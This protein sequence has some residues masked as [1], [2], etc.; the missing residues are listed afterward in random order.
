MA[1]YHLSVKTF[2]RAKAHAATAAAAYR[3]ADRIY[4]ERTGVTHDYTRK[5]G[6]LHCEVVLPEAAPHW[7]EKRE[8]LWNQAEAAEHRKNSTVAR[9]FELALPNEL[10]A[11]LRTELA[12]AFTRELVDRHGFAA[13][14]ALHEPH[15]E[16]DQRNYHAHI[17]VTTR[18]LVSAGFTDKTRELDAN[19]DQIEHWR[20]RWADLQNEYLRE[21]GHDARVDH[22]TLKEQGFVR[23]PGRH[24]G[25]AITALERRGERTVVLERRREDYTME[26]QRRLER[27][28]EIGRLQVQF[29][30]ICASIIDLTADLESARRER[31]IER[32]KDSSENLR[33]HA[34]QLW[35][36][37]K[38]ECEREERVEL[39]NS[40]QRQREKGLDGP[41]YDP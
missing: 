22:R 39:E 28:A 3:A 25:P 21:Y 13:D 35:I 10:S 33:A 20:A 15:R 27:A 34:V 36:D 38:A 11:V 26:T 41:D 17:L 14:L 16:G 2:S 18:R 32:T 40:K 29:R 7:A 4:D 24:N 12:R 1:S 5:R 19:P 31:E 37:W 23:E 9:E 8:Q 6:V 30:D